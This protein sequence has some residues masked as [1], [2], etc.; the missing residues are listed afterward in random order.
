MIY[1]I[2]IEICEKLVFTI[3]K[4]QSCQWFNCKQ[5]TYTYT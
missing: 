4:L 2:F 3:Q 1:I 5:Y